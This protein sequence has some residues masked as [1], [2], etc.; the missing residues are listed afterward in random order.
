MDGIQ[1]LTHC[2]VPLPL[3]IAGKCFRNTFTNTPFRS[4]P[5]ISRKPIFRCRSIHTEP[6]LFT[7]LARSLIR[8]HSH[9][10]SLVAGAGWFLGL[11]DSKKQVLPEIVK[12]GDPVLHEPT[13]EVPPEDIGSERIQKIIDDMVQVMRKAPGVGLAAPQ[14]GIPLK[15][16]FFFML[17]CRLAKF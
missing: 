13:Q 2:L 5:V 14:I 15:V 8:R 17:V 16:S 6:A 12:A 1:R 10:S 7:K 3:P 9:N 11:S 4:L